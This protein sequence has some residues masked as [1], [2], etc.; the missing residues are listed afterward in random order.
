MKVDNVPYLPLNGCGNK[1]TVRKLSAEP[2]SAPIK[3][4]HSSNW[5]KKGQVP[6]SSFLTV[7]FDA[8]GFVSLSDL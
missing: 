5:Q 3:P 4:H 6:P 8:V 7:T 2:L 1:S